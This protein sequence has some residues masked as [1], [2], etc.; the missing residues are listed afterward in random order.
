MVS[1]CIA[2]FY[3]ANVAIDSEALTN[4]AITNDDG[5]GWAVASEKFGIEI[6]KSMKFEE[7]L[8]DFIEA[9]ERHGADS[10][11]M[12]H[13]RFATH[14]TV[15]TFNVHP[16]WVGDDGQT[17]MVHNGILPALFHPESKDPR[18]DTQLFADD[19]LKMFLRSET[20]IPSRRQGKRLGEVIGAG[21]KFIIMSV[22]SGKPRVR[23]IN[24]HMGEHSGGAWYSNSG[25]IASKWTYRG[26]YNYGH[27]NWWDDDERWGGG[28]GRNVTT[29]GRGERSLCEVD[30]KD[31]QY[32]D[33][34][35]EVCLTTGSVSL[36]TDLCEACGVCQSCWN[37][38]KFCSCPWGMAG[39]RE[40]NEPTREEIEE[41]IAK[42]D[43]V[44]ED[45]PIG[46][47][48]RFVEHVDTDGRTFKIWE[49]YEVP[50][51][52][53]PDEMAWAMD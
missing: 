47:Y 22:A 12:F 14:G 34:P 5:H 30:S 19:W 15:D 46:H 50:E 52:S 33:S 24:A 1:I 42:M 13:S 9:R 32:S 6:G 44:A 48:G 23:I 31:W 53:A 26:T 21:N 29:F 20:G 35:C 49:S 36:D 4:G 38:D 28:Y 3:P 43:E 11:A 10:L 39:Q 45:N 2:S 37:E 27:G 7:S 8:A 18:S 40:G 25:Y 41:A 16:F 51:E 17:V